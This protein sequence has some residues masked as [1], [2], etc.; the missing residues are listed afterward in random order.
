MVMTKLTMIQ[1]QVND[2]II[3]Y[4]IREMNLRHAPQC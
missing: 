1:R 4:D 3:S 2:G